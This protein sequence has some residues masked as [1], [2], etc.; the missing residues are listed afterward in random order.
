MEQFDSEEGRNAS[1]FFFIP[2][3]NNTRDKPFI[4]YDSPSDSVEKLRGVSMNTD[5][6]FLWNDGHVWK[7]DLESQVHS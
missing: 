7:I 4:Y 1:V 2:N 3:K 5:Y 6:I